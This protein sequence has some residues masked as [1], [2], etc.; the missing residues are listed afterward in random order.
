M[1]AIS[2]L[3]LQGIALIN[4]TQMITALTVEGQFTFMFF[5]HNS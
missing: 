3:L 4:G 5:L 1:N 2:T